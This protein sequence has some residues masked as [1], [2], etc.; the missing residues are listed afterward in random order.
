MVFEYE[1][2]TAPTTWRAVCASQIFSK[3]TGHIASAFKLLPNEQERDVDVSVLASIARMVIESH[4]ALLYFTQRGL[5]VE[6]QDFRLTLYEYHSSFESAAV[7]DRL[8]I[9]SDHHWN[10]FFVREN[11]CALSQKSFFQGL[12]AKEQKMLLEGRKA[13]YWR[14]QRP[15]PKFISESHE[16]A[17]Y[18]L[19]SNHVHTFP[20]GATFR[21]GPSESIFG[22]S[23]IAFFALEAI[24]MYSAATILA[25][26]S[27]RVKV[28]QVLSAADKKYLRD[29]LE[30]RTLANWLSQASATV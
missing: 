11:K 17:L 1:A 16:S 24:V 7:L 2:Q 28:G 27:F 13:Y 3:F 6:E 19:M 5:S 8:G 10:D 23:C 30:K 14:G 15:K 4:D 9:P 29:V 22:K 25:F 26:A 18:K 21:F 20:L 12:P